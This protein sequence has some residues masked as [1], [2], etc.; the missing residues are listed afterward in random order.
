[1]L[2]FE[3]HFVIGITNI[4]ESLTEPDQASQQIYNNSDTSG[5]VSEAFPI[6]SGKQQELVESNQNISNKV[7]HLSPSK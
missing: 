6:F 2:K 1:M 5:Q 7:Q 3:N 4:P